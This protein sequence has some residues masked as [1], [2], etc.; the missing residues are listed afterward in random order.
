MTLSTLSGKV[1]QTYPNGAPT[2][3]LIDL[4]NTEQYLGIPAANGYVLTGNTDGTRTWT[5]LN[6]GNLVFTTVS[7]TR[8]LTGFIDAA[9]ASPLTV[10]STAINGGQFIITIASFSPTFGTTATPSTLNWDQTPTSFA[11]TVTNPTDFTDLYISNVNTLTT[12]TGTF[13]ALSSFTGSAISPTP[14]GSWTKTYTMGS[15]YI[16]ASAGSSSSTAGGTASATFSYIQK[17][18]P[19]GVETAYTGTITG[20][21]TFTFTW[22]SLATPTISMTSLGTNQFINVIT[23][24]TF[25]ATSSTTLSTASNGSHVVAVGTGGTI[26]AATTG[27]LAG[28]QITNTGSGT[29]AAGTFTFTTPIN[30]TAGTSI[31]GRTLT[32]TSTF[33]RPAAISPGGTG[34]TY[35]YSPVTS[36]AISATWTYPSLYLWGTYNANPATVVPVRTDILGSTTWTASVTILNDQQNTY[37]AYVTNSDPNIRYLWFGVLASI[38]QPSSFQ[39]GSGPSLLTPIPTPTAYTVALYPTSTPAVTTNYKLYPIPLNTGSSYISIS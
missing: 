26:T 22:N 15:G 35:A 19:G 32:I 30:S 3:S 5:A 6:G 36:G 2:G 16:R 18:N 33:T 39:V 17:T 7:N 10:R 11:T 23:S 24:T 28:G 27:T 13:A 9:G 34:Y 12:V 25:T 8:V 14:G 38:T 29:V 20:T 31:T 1:V 21:A 37:A 4:S